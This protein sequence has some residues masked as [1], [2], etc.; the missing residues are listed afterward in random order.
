[1]IGCFEYWKAKPHIPCKVC[2]K[3]TSSEPGLYR[4]HSGTYYVIQYFNKLRDK[5][6]A[7]D[8]IQMKIDELLLE[9]SAN[10]TEKAGEQ[11][12]QIKALQVTSTIA[13]IM[14]EKSEDTGDKASIFKPSD[15]VTILQSRIITSGNIS[16]ALIDSDG[17]DM[18]LGLFGD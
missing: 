15:E 12:P 4:K 7:D 11:G 13:P 1:M 14:S 9:L 5:A 16:K 2:G 3:P 18:G 10:K 6:N 17:E 8:L